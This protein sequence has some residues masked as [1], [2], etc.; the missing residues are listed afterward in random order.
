MCEP[1]S[2]YQPAVTGLGRVIRSWHLVDPHY[3]TTELSALDIFLS[4]ITHCL[5]YTP[6]LLGSKN[7]SLR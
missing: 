3:D 2:S 5:S 4:N 7:P 6:D 1:L